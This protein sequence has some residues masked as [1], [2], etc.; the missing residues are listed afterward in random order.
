MKR[1]ELSFLSAALFMVL[2]GWQRDN[3]DWRRITRRVPAGDERSASPVRIGF[4]VDALF[5]KPFD[6]GLDE[7]AVYPSALSADQ[8]GRHHA[9][10]A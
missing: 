8:I 3:F 9:A 7:I 5:N 6:G 4:W 10:A 1:S 2:S